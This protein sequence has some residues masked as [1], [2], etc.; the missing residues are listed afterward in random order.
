[1]AY[2]QRLTVALCLALW[3]L[4]SHALSSDG[5]PWSGNFFGINWSSPT[6]AATAWVADTNA[7]YNSP[8]FKSGDCFAGEQ[9]TYSL[10]KPVVSGNVVSVTVHIRGTAGC[11]HNPGYSVDPVITA[12][13]CTQGDGLVDGANCSSGPNPIQDTKKWQDSLKALNASGDQFCTSQHQVTSA[14]VCVDDF[15][16]YGSVIAAG[17]GK[18]ADGTAVQC[19]QGPFSGTGA[20]C[21]GVDKTASTKDTNCTGGKV[22]GTVNGVTVCVNPGTKTTT[23]TTNDASGGGSGDSNSSNTTSTTTCDGVTCT[24]TKTTT[25]TTT[26]SS[27]SST[28]TTTTS[29]TS[30]PQATY[31]ASNPTSAQCTDKQSSFSGSCASTACTGDAIQCAIAQEQAKRDCALFDTASDESNLYATN[32]GKTGSQTG[33]LPGND[34]V[35]FSNSIDSSDALGGGQCVSDLAITVMGKAITL[36]FSR[37]CPELELLGRALLV[38]SWLLAIRIVMRG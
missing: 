5:G 18:N 22:P 28:P 1:M 7:Y 4:A 24:T 26:T 36:P 31:C 15:A 14:I 37:V 35:S 29:T 11:V 23:T 25:T 33:D 6:A 8:S 13:L 19:I 9:Y 34:S 2:L 21:D 38:V 10:D 17:P 3:C 16:V 27:G 20:S 12:T 32:K 30:V